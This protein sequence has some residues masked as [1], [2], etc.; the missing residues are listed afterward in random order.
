VYGLEGRYQGS[1]ALPAVSEDHVHDCLRSLKIQKS[2][3]PS[4]MYPRVPRELADIVVKPLLMIFEKSWWSGEN[5]C[6]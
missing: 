3:G 4:E 6:D 1:S 2:M 5:S